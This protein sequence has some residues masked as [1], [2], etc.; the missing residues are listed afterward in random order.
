MAESKALDAIKTCQ[1]CKR[2]YATAQRCGKLPVQYELSR[3]QSSGNKQKDI[4]L[5]FKPLSE[6]LANLVK[7]MSPPSQSED[8]NIHQNPTRFHMAT[9]PVSLPILTAPGPGFVEEALAFL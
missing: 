5:T 7:R 8:S 3:V 6:R 1:E 9:A 4:R 2:L